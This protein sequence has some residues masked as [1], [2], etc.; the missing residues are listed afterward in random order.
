MPKKKLTKAQVKRKMADIIIK[1]NSLI[2]DK[3]DHVDSFTP[4]SVNKLLEIH[5]SMSNAFK[6][7]K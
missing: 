6:R 5:K 1:L 3:L 7:I 2:M 4:V